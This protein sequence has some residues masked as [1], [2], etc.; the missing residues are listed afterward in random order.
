MRKLAER[1]RNSTTEIAGTV[2]RVQVDTRAAVT[3][4][5]SSLDEVEQGVVLAHEAG[6][7]IEQMRLGAQRVVHVVRDFSSAVGE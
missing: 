7:A 3:S 2:D 1:T 5:N 6:T 4:M